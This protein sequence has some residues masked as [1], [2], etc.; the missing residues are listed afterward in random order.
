MKQDRLYML[1]LA[2]FVRKIREQFSRGKETFLQDTTVHD[3]T[4]MG[5]IQIGEI[6]RKLSPAFK[7][8]HALI[9]WQNMIDFRNI[10][11]H[12]YAGIDLHIVWEIMEKDFPKLE[13]F[14]VHYLKD[15]AP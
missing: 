7:Q 9:P 1:H 2:D 6:A 5:F 14:V 3:S 15:A 8:Q 10:L 11:V 4:L 12:N 13:A